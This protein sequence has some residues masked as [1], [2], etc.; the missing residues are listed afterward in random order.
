[1][2]NYTILAVNKREGSSM[3]ILKSDGLDGRLNRPKPRKNPQKGFSRIFCG[4]SR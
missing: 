3:S 1:M 4:V 2:V